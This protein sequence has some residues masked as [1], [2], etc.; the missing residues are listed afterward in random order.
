MEFDD[1]KLK[2][3]EQKKKTG[4]LVQLLAFSL[5]VITER[6]RHAIG[7]VVTTRSIWHSGQLSGSFNSKHQ[8]VNARHP[9]EDFDL[10]RRTSKSPL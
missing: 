10:I 3:I 1:I 7:V 2:V 9:I 6:V 5:G 4:E 8:L